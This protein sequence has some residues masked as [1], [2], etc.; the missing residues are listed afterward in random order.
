M[1]TLIFALFLFSFF[2][3]FF[4]Y[5]DVTITDGHAIIPKDRKFVNFDNLRVRKINKTHHLLAGRVELMR[6]IGDIFNFQA[7]IYKKSGNAYQRTALHFGP[8]N[9]CSYIKEDRFLWPELLKV[10]DLPQN[11]TCPMLKGSYNIF[12]YDIQPNLF[13]IKFDGD[14]MFETR[15]EDHEGEV[16]NGYQMYASYIY[17]DEGN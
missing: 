7:L 14:Y 15:L 6:D 12:G 4:C 9:F 3:A 10:F 1:T 16:L 17:I 13:P 2:N 5:H 11:R 8:K